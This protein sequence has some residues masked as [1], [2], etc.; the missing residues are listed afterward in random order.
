MTPFYFGTRERRLFGVYD[1]AAQGQAGLEKI[2]AVVLCHPWGPEYLHAHRAMR[3]LAAK[4]TSA[5]FHVLRFDYFGTGNSA[6]DVEAVDIKGWEADIELAMEELKDMTGATRVALV[7]LRLGATLAA[8]VAARRPGE[9]S[10]LVLWDPLVSGEEYLES[11]SPK[12]VSKSLATLWPAAKSRDSGGRLEISG[13]TLEPAF[14]QEMRSLDL[15]PLAPKLPDRTLII[16]TASLD[17][18]NSFRGAL[19]GRE[20]GPLA[21]EKIESVFPW[22]EDSTWTGTAPTNVVQRIVQW[23]K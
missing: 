3:Q 10:A 6:G 22:I 8:E 20:A 21:I 23:L 9:V 4:L 14:A 17:S 15:S 19:A 12:S 5:G 1:S 18:H 11:L 13:F 2:R 16:A 7:G